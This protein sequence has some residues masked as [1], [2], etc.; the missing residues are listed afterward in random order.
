M[1]SKPLSKVTW[2]IA[3]LLTFTLTTGCQ[4]LFKRSTLSISGSYKTPTSYLTP[5]ANGTP[6][7]QV[8]P[9][10]RGTPVFDGGICRTV[11]GNQY[12]LRAGRLYYIFRV[13]HSTAEGVSREDLPSLIEEMRGIHAEF[14]DLDPPSDCEILVELDFAYEAE[15]DQTLR[16]YIAFH[17][18]EPEDIWLN[19]YLNEALFYSKRI[20]E[21]LERIY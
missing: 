2:L 19:Y 17:N 14:R 13:F 15:I 1:L 18:L 12:L 20:E 7:I 16:G 3:I 4:Y 9:Y 6:A 5:I 11:A 8:T 21:L 10:P